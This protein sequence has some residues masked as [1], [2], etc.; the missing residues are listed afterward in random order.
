MTTGTHR[1][2]SHRRVAERRSAWL[3]LLSTPLF[4]AVAFAVGEGLAALLGLEEG[5]VATFTWRELVVLV[6][7]IAVLAV[8]AVGAVLVARRAPHDRVAQLPAW[9]LVA[10]VG[11]FL[12]TNLVGMV[13][14]SG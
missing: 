11:T 12:V 6:V 1:A 8:P 14:A 2:H 3:W 4:F 10:L 7:A 13:S 5:A 9:L